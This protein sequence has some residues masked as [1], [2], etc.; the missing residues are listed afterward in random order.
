MNRKEIIEMKRRQKRKR[1]SRGQKETWEKRGEEGSSRKVSSELQG[2]RLS[3]PALLA[4][5]PA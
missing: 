4:H 5:P 1:G 2:A 3:S